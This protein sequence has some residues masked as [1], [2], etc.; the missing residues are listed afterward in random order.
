MIHSFGFFLVLSPLIAFI[1]VFIFVFI[2]ILNVLG[3]GLI[4]GLSILV[5]SMGFMMVDEAF[6]VR[7]SQTRS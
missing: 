5:L 6:E 1:W 7:E 2:V 4:L 3:A